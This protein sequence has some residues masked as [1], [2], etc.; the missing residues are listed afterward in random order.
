MACD[1]KKNKANSMAKSN[2]NIQRAIAAL[3]LQNGQ[4]RIAIAQNRRAIRR[5]RVGATSV[6]PVSILNRQRVQ[7]QRAFRENSSALRNLGIDVCFT[8]NCPKGQVCLAG[9]CITP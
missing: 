7:L 6:G 8:T 5:V 3:V 2:I 9:F 1:C 4:L